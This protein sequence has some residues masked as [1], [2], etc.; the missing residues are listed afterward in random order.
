M[1]LLPSIGQ[2]LYMAK[3]LHF[4]IVYK[5]SKPET[6]VLLSSQS[7]SK[8]QTNVSDNPIYRS[9]GDKHGQV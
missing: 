8:N 3:H 1:T 2:N 4:F 9:N 6:G 7:V 5:Q